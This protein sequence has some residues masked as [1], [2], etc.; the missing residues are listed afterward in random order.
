[1]SSWPCP[2][3]VFMLVHAPAGAS[4]VHSL[5]PSIPPPPPLSAPP[6]PLSWSCLQHEGRWPAG[7]G[8]VPR[9]PL[10]CARGHAPG[11]LHGAAPARHVL[12]AARGHAAWHLRRPHEPRAAEQRAPL[13][14]H[15][16]QRRGGPPRRRR[17][18]WA[19]DEFGAGPAARCVP[20]GPS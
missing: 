6:S 16:L 20:H 11:Q 15:R 17:G 14:G 1:M 12:A 4:L 13:P 7:G 18:P 2:P 10:P 5:P 3:S 8:A 19:H 9:G